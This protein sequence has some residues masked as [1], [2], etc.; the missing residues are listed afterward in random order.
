MRDLLALLATYQ[1]SFRTRGKRYGPLILK[2]FCEAKSFSESKVQYLCSSLWCLT[3]EHDDDDD[4]DDIIMQ[5]GWDCFSNCSHQ[6]VYCLSSRWYMSMEYHGGIMPTEE[7]SWFVHQS[8][9]AFLLIGITGSKQEE[10]AKE[11]VNLA[12]RSL[13][14]HTCKWYFTCRKILWHGSS[15]FTSPRKEGVLRIISLKNPLSRLG[16]NPRTLGLMPRTLSITTRRRQD[17]A[18]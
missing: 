6:Q 17:G 8:S 12:S 5:V 4:D 9:V 16:L 3:T 10:R 2:P 13:F 11:M 18:W 7:T 1:S 14:I 15:G